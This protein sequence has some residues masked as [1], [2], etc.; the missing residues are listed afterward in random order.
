[1]TQRSSPWADGVGDGGAYSA[2][3]LRLWFKALTDGPGANQGVFAG[4]L[5]TFAVTST[6]ANNIRVAS[7]RAL[8][9]GTLYESDV[10]VV[11]TTAS[12]TVGTTGRRVVLRKVWST[13][14]VRAVILSSADG[15]AALPA[16]TQTDGATWEIPLASFTITTAGVIGALADTRE[17]LPELTA[18]GKVTSAGVLSTDAVGIVSVSKPATGQYTVTFARPQ[19]AVVAGAA[20]GLRTYTANVGRTSSTVYQVFTQSGS[21]F[22]ATDMAFE[23]IGRP[24]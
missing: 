2:D 5:N 7:G 15:T 23:I 11:M 1:M 16:L 4:Q 17:Y 18:A 22:A 3:Y 8:V 9:D 12:P 21:T 14:T 10:E 24:L 6:G 19:I 13:R 20:S